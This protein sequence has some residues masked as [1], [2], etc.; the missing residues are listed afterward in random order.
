MKVLPTTTTIAW[1]VLCQVL[2]RAAAAEFAVT[3]VAVDL[4]TPMLI[5]PA[6]GAMLRTPHP[7]FSW[8]P[9]CQPVA[10]GA[11]CTYAIEVRDSATQG[12]G[13]MVASN[14]SSVITRFV[15]LSP[16]PLGL[17][18]DSDSAAGA[19]EWRVA[20]VSTATTQP[21]SNWS[22]WH[23]FSVGRAEPRPQPITN[24]TT[25]AEMQAIFAQAC[26]GA[27]SEGGWVRF[28]PPN[29][30]RVL[31][32][33]AG[34][35]TFLTLDSCAPGVL[36]DF[37]GA[38]LTFTRRVG[39][40]AVTNCTGLAVT[41]LLLDLDP[42]PYSAISLDEVSEDGQTF[43]GSL[44][45]GHPPVETLNI[46]SRNTFELVDPL[47]TRTARG[48]VEVFPFDPHFRRVS[49]RGSI[50]DIGVAIGNRGSPEA[51]T[52]DG[53]A[54][55][56]AAAGPPIRYN[57][58]LLKQRGKLD[59][60]DVGFVAVFGERTGAPGFS[61]LGGSGVTFANVTVQAC[62]NECFTSSHTS[63]LSILG[64]GIVLRPG[65][66]KAANDGGHNHHSS[67]VGAW[68]EGGRWE[69]TGDDICHV[70]SLVASADSR[71]DNAN[72]STTLGLRC[73]SGD[74]YCTHNMHGA[75][76]QV[77]VGDVI[78]FFNRSSG[79]MVAERTVASLF[80]AA[81]ATTTTTATSTT[82]TATATTAAATT[83]L[84][85]ADAAAGGAEVELG[86]PGQLQT[87][88][89]LAGPALPP[90]DLGVIGAD[91]KSLQ[92]VTNVFD[93]NATATQFVFKG[94]KVSCQMTALCTHVADRCC[95]CVAATP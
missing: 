69:S 83:D 44:M 66:F 58:T 5:S 10:I 71:A 94:N 6:P 61:V 91:P 55:A 2:V 90:I 20:S 46:T 68:V 95:R 8:A 67:R 51:R 59:Q 43:V 85:L 27:K 78:Q 63:G 79:K 35:D 57:V 70:S 74:R 33:G 82:A 24:T 54:A 38:A 50:D 60:R 76:E 14:T 86:R 3:L 18:G 72:G 49:G 17:V 11:Q 32:P 77:A 56:A 92:A 89:T 23:P 39:F 21:V 29:I 62:A 64:G 80:T 42:L 1:A 73:S 40:F 37:N 19:Y 22:S 16:M 13:F 25:Y 47:T 65:R 41:N 53:E 52:N 48:H 34:A 28:E 9:S 81:T 87:F 31:D 4:D 88:V 26:S 75:H 12:A 84:S 15:P 93:L 30:R 36:L 7:H 45:A